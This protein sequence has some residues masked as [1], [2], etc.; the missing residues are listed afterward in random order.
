LVWSAR[1]DDFGLAYVETQLIEHP[2]R[3]PGQYFDSET[4]LH[5]NGV[6]YYDPRLGVFLGGGE[7]EIDNAQPRVL[8]TLADE[9]RRRGVPSC[10]AA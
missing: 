7:N 6:R 10:C 9:L 3:F 4:E 5:Y 1:Y 8:P 2:L